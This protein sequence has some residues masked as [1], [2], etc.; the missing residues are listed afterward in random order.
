[1]SNYK[2]PLRYGKNT[3]GLDARDFWPDEDGN[4]GL[5]L[6]VAGHLSIRGTFSN[7]EV[8]KMRRQY[9]FE[10]IVGLVIL[11][12]AAKVVTPASSPQIA[13]QDFVIK[14]ARAGK[15]E[16]D[17]GRMAADKGRNA[18]VRSFGRRMVTDHTK[19]GDKLKMIAAK[20]GVVLPADIDPEAK[21]KMDQLMQLNGAEF[22]RNYMEMM[23]GDHETAVGDFQTEASSGAAAE[24]KAF[25]TSTLPKLKLHL[26]LAKQIAAKVK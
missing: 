15:M 6:A 19:A 4:C 16:V 24:V 10:V 7:R 13:D 25:A 17:L 5:F 8:E 23:V 12:S 9:S 14:A 3:E 11:F 21:A 20:K 2:P 1:M 26:R 22:D 18:A